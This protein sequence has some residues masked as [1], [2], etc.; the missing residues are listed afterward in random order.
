MTTLEDR[1]TDWAAAEL[2]GDAG[3]LEALL[4]PDFLAVGPYGFLLDRRQWTRRF[5]DGLRYTAFALTPDAPTRYVGGSAVVVGTQR[6][7]GTHQGRTV[8]GA[9]RVTLVLTDAPEW[10]VAAVHLSLRDLPA[11]QGGAR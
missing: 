7:E 8:D 9:F 6:Q 5:A 4:H 3:R 2:S 10:R 11:G 1:L